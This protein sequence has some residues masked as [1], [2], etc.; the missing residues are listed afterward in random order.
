MTP[1]ETIQA[2]IARVESIQSR[3]DEAKLIVHNCNRLDPHLT[4]E[5]HFGDAGID[6]DA[7]I[8]ARIMLSNQGIQVTPYS[9]ACY[10]GW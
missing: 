6:A 3:Y 7:V 1:L 10:L 2:A 9:I 4:C 5:H 8:A